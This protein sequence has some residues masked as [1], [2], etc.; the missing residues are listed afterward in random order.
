MN[1]SVW[2][3]IGENSKMPVGCFNSLDEA[4]K[5]IS[6]QELSGLL[7]QYP[8]NELAYDW[9]IR[10]QFFQPKKPEQKTANFIGKFTSASQVHFHF[11]NGIKVG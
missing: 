9:A 7:T 3:F 1:D 11:E 10:N 2:V 6:N 4:I 5:T 8:I